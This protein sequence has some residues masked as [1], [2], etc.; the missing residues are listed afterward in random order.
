MFGFFAERALA[1]QRSINEGIPS[2]TKNEC[3]GIANRRRAIKAL[4]ADRRAFDGQS[5]GRPAWRMLRI[6][7]AS[8]YVA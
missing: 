3:L 5:R 4:A 8:N 2:G 7:T 6:D 1:A